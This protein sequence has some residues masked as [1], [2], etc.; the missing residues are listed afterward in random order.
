MTQAIQHITQKDT[1][2]PTGLR[3]YLKTETPEAIWARGSVDLLPGQNA[4]FETP[5]N[6]SL[7]QLGARWIETSLS[8]FS[9]TEDL[10]DPTQNR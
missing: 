10:N 7:F 6:D 4:T 8:E 3:Q 1:D 2:Y 9:P 5:A